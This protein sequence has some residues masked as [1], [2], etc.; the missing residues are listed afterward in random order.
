MNIFK[1]G[2]Q[3]GTYFFSSRAGTKL[4]KVNDCI[5]CRDEINILYSKTFGNMTR[6]NPSK[7]WFSRQ[8]VNFN[9]SGSSSTCYGA[10]PKD[11]RNYGCPLVIERFKV[12]FILWEIAKKEEAA[13]VRRKTTSTLLIHSFLRQQCIW[14]IIKITQCSYFDIRQLFYIKCRFHFK[15]FQT[16]FFSNPHAWGIRITF[17]S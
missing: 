12:G 4:G 16:F 6:P 15:N 10:D 3:D 7:V 5:V 14:L 11:R 17:T 8:E 1:R 2:S 9:F 13:A